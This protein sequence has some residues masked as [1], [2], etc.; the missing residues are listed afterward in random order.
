MKREGIAILDF[1]GQYAHLIAKRLR[2]QSVYTE[3]LSPTAPLADLHGAHGIVLSG[4]PASVTAHEAPAFNAALLDTGRPV[5]GICYGHQ[6]LVQHFGGAVQPRVE[7]EF[8]RA[9]LA[10]RVP[11]RLLRGLDREETVWVSHGDSAEHLPPGFHALAS[12]ST[13]QV[14]AMEDPHRKLFGVQFH[15]EVTH[16]PSGS[17]VLANFLEACR[18][19]RTWSAEHYAQLKIEE[20]R[21]HV[22]RRK[23]FLFV[24]GG[25]DS[26]VAYALLVRAIGSERVLGVLVDHGFLRHDEAPS[27]V[28]CLTGAG[29]PPILVRDEVAA[30]GAATASARDPETKRVAIGRAF[31]EVQRSVARDLD[32][33]PREWLLG[34]GTLYPDTI[35]SGGTAHADAIKTHHNR[36]EEIA[37][38]V[39]Q[40]LVVEPLVELYKDEVRRIGHELGL[41]ANII[42][43]HPFPGPGLAVR[44]LCGDEAVPPVPKAL[45]AKVVEMARQYGFEASVLPVR[46]VGV[47]GDARTYAA[48]AVLWGEALDWS[49]LEAASIALTNA[50]GGINRVV[51]AISPVA[52]VPFEPHP[53]ALDA[54]RI[55]LARE[56]DRIATEILAAAGDWR[57]VWQM[58]VVLAPV[59]SQSYGET[60]ILR[61]VGSDDAMTARFVGLEPDLVRETAERLRRLRLVSA[62][63]YDITHKPPGTIEW[64]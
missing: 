13:C 48:A 42:E 55:A 36:V 22:G 20:L 58:P 24:S 61:P 17:R 28:R 4:G 27:V 59:S 1:G 33:N 11:G 29:L 45:T 57:E 12:T 52:P 21:D 6:L 25:V 54:E 34:Q 3:I 30:F 46:S 62:V 8:G 15:P 51:C 60:V 9:T 37:E 5:L 43:R 2:G 50:I 53:A 38:L 40:G 14:A 10:V 18:P 44:M 32:L 19:P 39:E 56:A 7:R 23:V 31:L 63:L 41:P 35:E 16:T 64:E 49:S 47:Q 26:V